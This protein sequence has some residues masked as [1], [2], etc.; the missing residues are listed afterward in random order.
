M[1]G[2]NPI[3]KQ[4]LGDGRSLRIVEGS[5]F[6]TIQGEGPFAGHP[7]VFVRLH[8][9]NLRCW[10]CDTNFSDPNDPGIHMIRL[11]RLIYD[12]CSFPMNR[13]GKT[14]LVVITGGEPFVQNIVPLCE[15]LL[16][17]G[18]IVQIETA[19]TLWIEGA[20]NLFSLKYG[21]RMNMVVSPKTPI[22]HEMIARYASAYKYVIG[23]ETEVTEEGIIANTQKEDGPKRPLAQPKSNVPIYLSPMDEYNPI[24]NEMNRKRIAELC[25]EKGWIAGVQLHKLLAISEPS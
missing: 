25:L 10:F 6:Y 22:V 1:F 14:N 16:E 11:A 3:E 9:C 7:A 19:G 21:Q 17:K 23:S 13:H 2:K 12:E 24:I 18:F 20:E 4:S 15:A 8:G 5:P